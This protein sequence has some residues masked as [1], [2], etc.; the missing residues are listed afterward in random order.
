[1]LAALLQVAALQLPAALIAGGGIH[2]G[3]QVRQCLAAGAQA[4]Q[5]DS[6]VGVEPGQS[7]RGHG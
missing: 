5:I 6:A 3:E 2:T 7:G 4:V 1:M